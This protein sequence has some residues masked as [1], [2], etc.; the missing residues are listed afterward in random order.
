MTGG[1]R[2]P[3][4]SLAIATRAGEVELHGASHLIDAAGAIALRANG[5]GAADGARAVTRLANFLTRG[6]ETYLSATDGLP[7]IDVQAVLEIGT[8]FRTAGGSRVFAPVT[9]EL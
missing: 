3:Q 8:F 6:I 1:A 2:V 7:E 4:P 9:E 5:G